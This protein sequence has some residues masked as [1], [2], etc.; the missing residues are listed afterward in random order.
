MITVPDIIFDLSY[1]YKSKFASLNDYSWTTVN[2]I[3]KRNGTVY[4]NMAMNV[5]NMN[6]PSF[7]L[8]PIESKPFLDESRHWFLSTSNE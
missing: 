5:N 1:L 8:N 2:G 4:T 6:F 3:K 7:E